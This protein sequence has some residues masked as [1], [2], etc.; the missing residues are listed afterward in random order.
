MRRR[1]F[2][3]WVYLVQ[4]I[5]SVLGVGGLSCAIRRWLLNS[6]GNRIAP[7]ARIIGGGFILGRA[8]SV[9]ERSSIG[10]GTYIDLSDSVTLGD[11]VCVGHGC[12]FITANHEVGP[13]ER[14]CGPLTP[15]PIVVGN[16]VWIAANVMVMP[17]VTIGPGAIIPA[18]SI[19]RK[20]VAPNSFFTPDFRR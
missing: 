6:V 19:V 8:L 20:D 16:G 3:L 11:D 10:R 15:G 17:G 1:I 12:V 9:G 13:P 4:L 5:S 14:R 7:G 2:E 18:G